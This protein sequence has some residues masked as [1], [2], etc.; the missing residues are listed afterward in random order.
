VT[1]IVRTTTI[2]ASLD[3]VFAFHLDTRNAAAIA[4]RGTTVLRVDGTFPVE[5]GDRVRLSVRQRP[6]P[7][8]QRW[9]VEIE[10][11]EAPTTIVDRM[12]EG[13]FAR[14]RH[15]RQFVAVAGGVEMTERLD[16]ALPLGSL[17][18]IV[19]RL[20]V[21]RMIGR[22]FSERQRLTRELLER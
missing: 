19:D 12:I 22:T 1:V 7:W 3:D 8:V 18:Q 11:V 15:A 16:Y 13:P 4:P 17:G 2:R 20:L 10:V 5:Q 6:L 21:R 14:W 9:L